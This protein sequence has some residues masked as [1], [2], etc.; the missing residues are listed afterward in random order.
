MIGGMRSRLLLILAFLFAPLAA[1]P[2]RVAAAASLR[3]ALDEAAAAFMAA[4]PDA[5]IQ[6]SYGAS[7]SLTAQIQQGAPFDLFLAADMDY[8]AKAAAEGRGRGE[9][10]AFVTG[11]LA[12]WTR[13]ELGLDPA[14]D[15][16]AALKDPRIAHIALANPKLAP[17][18]AAAEAALRASKLWDA[19][20]PRLVFGAN[21]GQTAQY[22]ALGSAE[23]G[24]IAAS[25]A[26]QAELA[27]K[28]NAW[29]VPASLHAPLVQGGVRL[30]NGSAPQLADSFTAYLRSDAGQAVFTRHGFGKP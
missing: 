9:V 10:F 26:G 5:D 29:I 20:Q 27:A 8:P 18:G 7:G 11:R 25:D 23:A 19:L 3:G 15:G 21:I 14:K 30:R 6:V 13:K 17:Y 16:L 4:H 1:Q 2:L 22:L 28:G 12:L 24:F